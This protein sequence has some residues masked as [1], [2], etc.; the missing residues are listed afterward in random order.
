VSGDSRAGRGLLVG[1]GPTALATA[2]EIAAGA[3]Q[4]AGPVTVQ[5][6]GGTGKTLLLQELAAAH[7]RSRLPVRTLDDVAPGSLPSE[8]FALLVDDAQLLTPDRA[9][10]VHRLLQLP[11]ARVVL[12]F[13]PWPRPAPLI[14]LVQG[15]PAT[16]RSV[17]LGHVDR[18]L[19]GSWAREL[20]GDG[21]P[22]GLADAVFAETGG[23]PGLVQPLLRGLAVRRHA[24]LRSIG[25]EWGST[26]GVLVVP[27]QVVEQLRADLAALDEGTASL[28]TAVAAGTPTDEEVLAQ[29]LHVDV[30]TASDLIAAGRATGLLLADGTLVLLAR[31]V[32]L[33]TT[34]A[35]VVRRIRRRLLGA[36]LDRGEDPLA[37][38]RTLA[39]DHVRD[40]RA[41]RLLQRHGEAALGDDPELASQLL[42]EAISSGA[43]VPQL[44]AQRAQAAALTGDLDGALRW[45][46]AALS[47]TGNPHRARAAGVTASVLAQRGL[48]GRAADLY[49]LTGREHA[50]ST[51]VALLA[52]GGREEAAA[53]MREA[54]PESAERMP[55]VSSVSEDLMAQ[56]LQLTLQAGPDTAATTAAA[57]SALTRAAALLEPVGRSVL[58]PDTPAALAALVA[59]HSGEPAIAESV[60]QRAVTAELGGPPARPRHLLLLAWLA[61]LA[62]RIP[63]A[64]SLAAQA[65]DCVEHLEPRDE[66]VLCALQ[67][68]VARR[69]GDVPALARAWERAREAVVRQPVDLFALLPLGELV[70]AAARLEE[71]TRLE[72]QVA[73]A[74]ALLDRLGNPRL[75]STTLHW[76]A[77]QAAILADDP[78]ALRP[79][80]AE[81][82]AAARTSRHAAVL[83]RAGRVWLRVLADDIEPERVVE[84]AQQLVGFGL[85]WDGSRLAGQAAAR[86]VDARVR[87]QLLACARETSD[88]APEETEDA[89]RDPAVA[90]PPPGTLSDREREVAR[91]VVAGQ[92]YREIGG[93]LYISAKTVEHHVSRMRQRL[94]AGT[95]S[96]LLA[97]LRAELAEGA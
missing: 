24:G 56:G 77:A 54:A 21:V 40:P 81:L 67:V 27:D 28:L 16:R 37:V 74:H 88:A 84:V 66:L 31:R 86:T 59:L 80:A 30:D 7:A 35:D 51:A 89:V 42:E 49:R 68:G 94:G 44:A 91:L 6:P 97:R 38:A 18:E 9:E 90:A 11:G 12:A 57:L 69:T 50:G 8:P 71:G 46:D 32:L 20:I 26:A 96:D 34:P 63:R 79:H 48:L 3:P 29:V 61:M 72:P 65:Q 52:T 39:A 22:A 5:G 58:L 70:V 55:T 25:S 23:L 78:V 43:P 83:A 15:L 73:A 60:L 64:G 10:V 1:S 93:R 82:L 95:R 19:V 87:S 4:Q 53:V 13:R 36:L 17:V 47:D 92:T 76:S 45:A 75:W 41:A 62:G 14:R 85:A 2:R 33:A